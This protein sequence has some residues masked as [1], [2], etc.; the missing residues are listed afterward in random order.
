M[1]T[2][3]SPV[4]PITLGLS[5][6]LL[7][8]TGCSRE[9]RSEAGTKMREAY[10]ESKAALTETWDKVKAYS[11]EKRDEF[12][13][14]ARSLGARMDS[15]L[16]ELRKNYSA[17]RAS[18]ARKAAMEELRNSEADYKAK[19]GA[20]GNAT[21]ATWDSAKQSVIAAWER[22]EASYRKARED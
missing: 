1:K 14:S 3:R 9:E 22:L 11:F 21:A 5:G 7:L 6:L 17:E 4:S 19:L 8:G 13:A 12:A 15:E 18:A 10:A 20:L 2:H 16:S